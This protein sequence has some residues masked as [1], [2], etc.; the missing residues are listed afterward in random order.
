VICSQCRTENETGR[1]FCMECGA[2]LA[3]GCPNCGAPNAAA[4]KFCGECGTT[5]TAATGAAAGVPAAAAP[6]L[7][8]A[9]ERRLVTVLF[10]DLVGFTTLA[11]DLDPEDTREFLTRYFDLTRTIVER[12]GGTVEKFIGD[13]VMA[14]WG[15]PTAHEDDAERAV[16]AALEI[17]RGVPGISERPGVDVRAGVLTGEAAV[18]VGATGQGMVAGDLVNTASRLQSVAPPGTVLVGETTYRAANSAISFE[19]AGEQLL[20]GKEAPVPAWRAVAVVGLRGG[21]GR[22]QAIE[23]PFTGRED[24]LRLLKDLFHATEREHKPRLV[25]VIGEGGIGKSR[26]VWELEKYIDGV[27][28]DVWWHVGRSPSYG[29][30]ISY[31][32]L[33][34]MVR[35]RAGIAETDEPAVALERLRAAVDEY[36]GDEQERHWIEPRLAGLLALEP[37]PAGTRDELFAAWRTFF[38]RIADRGPTVLVFE[39]VQWAD[40]GML[41]FI[42][43]LLDRARNRSIFVV[44]LARPEIHERRPGWGAN[45]RSGTAM[46]LEP[47]E[48]EQMAEMV[49]GTLPGISEAAVHAISDRAEGIPLYAVETMRMLIDRGDLVAAA[50]G[51]YEMKSSADTLAVP[52]T[53]QALIAARLDALG[54]HDRRLM[55]TAAVVGQSFTVEALAAVSGDGLEALRDQ[56]SALVKRQMLQVDV[57]PR[58]PERGQYQFVQAVVREIAEASLSRGDR[59]ALH[60]AAARYYESLG[61]EELA[62]VLASHYVEAYR[63]TPQGPEAD[64]LAAQARV[65]LRAAAERAIALHSNRQA[66]DYLEQALAVTPDPLEQAALHERAVEPAINES[67]YD[68]ALGHAR[69]AEA[70]ARE[71]GDRLGV[72]HAVTLQARVHLSHHHERPTIELLQPALQDVADVQPTRE[73]IEAQAQLARALMMGGSDEES[74][75]WSNRALAASGLADDSLLTDV[76][77][78][79]GTALTNSGRL[80]EGEIL[81][82]GAMQ[83]AE[84]SGDVWAALRA[85]NNVLGVVSSEDLAEA[86]TL[87]ADGYAIAMRHGLM[88]WAYQFAHASLSAAFERGDWDA[89]I[90]ETA[91]LD[92]PGFYGAWRIIEEGVRDALRGRIADGRRKLAAG[93]ERAGTDSTQAVTS[94]AGTEALLAFAAHDWEAVLPAARRAWVLIDSADSA[95]AAGAA[96]AAAANE[97]EWAREALSVFDGFPHRGRQPEGMRAFVETVI[98]LLDQHWPEAR[99]AYL[100]A[101]RALTDANALYSLALLNLSVAARGQGHIPEATEAAAAAREFFASVGADQFVDSYMA[102]IAPGPAAPVRTSAEQSRSGAPAS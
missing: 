1:K 40:E 56:L 26:L 59:R 2:P 25:S 36:V 51:R 45:V 14:V 15:A 65:S 74:V 67:L 24:E 70:L 101:R 72:L 100:A 39:D 77:I 69:A 38:E 29:S 46:T 62:G 44:T 84:R 54:E 48:P 97:P 28:G 7:S 98:A 82:R 9:A 83:V 75:E 95:I 52:E 63:A 64:A 13:A 32:A 22:S 50:G 66:V 90:D 8:G 58:S 96:A 18:T 16:R 33:A 73:I 47:L 23:P 92:A 76:L 19:A 12:Y 60:V 93:K 41:D 4:A 78:T 3:A 87:L 17:V 43:E 61:D 11:Q 6:R 49:R 99:A 42:E 80:V 34:E 71:R 31:W 68:E 20:K 91:A 89:W 94:I 79:K 102:A 55:Q 57:D 53:L 37:M 27:V 21:S 30:G 81:L 88:T 35:G 5:L 86:A 10:A 85:R